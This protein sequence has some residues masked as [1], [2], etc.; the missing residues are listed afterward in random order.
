MEVMTGVGVVP[1]YP[2]LGAASNLGMVLHL[3][4]NGSYDRSGGGTLVSRVGSC[5]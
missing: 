1:L 3:S 5:F 2:G 4:E